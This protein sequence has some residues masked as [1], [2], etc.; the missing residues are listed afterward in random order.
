MLL[1]LEGRELFKEIPERGCVPP[2]H[3]I[4]LKTLVYPEE[5]LSGSSR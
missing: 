5:A 1:G 3:D 2:P 4:P